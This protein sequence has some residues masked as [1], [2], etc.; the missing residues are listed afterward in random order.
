[1]A[2]YLI[3]MFLLLTGGYIIYGVARKWYVNRK[4]ERRLFQSNLY[5]WRKEMK[6][7]VHYRKYKN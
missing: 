7:S 3:V 1:M 4:R 5:K 2:T 6:D